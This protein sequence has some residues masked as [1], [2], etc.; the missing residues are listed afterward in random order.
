MQAHLFAADGEGIHHNHRRVLNVPE[1]F[2][3]EVAK[4]NSPK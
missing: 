4:I 1:E 3:V 2:R